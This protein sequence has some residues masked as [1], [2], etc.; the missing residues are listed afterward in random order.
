LEMVKKCH[1]QKLGPEALR[2]EDVLR[3]VNERKSRQ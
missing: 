1:A 2:A 3:A